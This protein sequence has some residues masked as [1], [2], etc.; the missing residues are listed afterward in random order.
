MIDE[1]QRRTDDERDPSE[2][3][4]MPG[5]M[6][7]M[8]RLIQFDTGLLVGVPLTGWPILEEPGLGLKESGIQLE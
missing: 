3:P 8:Q 4:R 5:L 7:W 6:Q 2:R 1:V